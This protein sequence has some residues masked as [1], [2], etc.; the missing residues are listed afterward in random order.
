[1][2]EKR[3]RGR[4]P[5]ILAILPQPGRPGREVYPGEFLENGDLDSERIVQLKTA[6]SLEEFVTKHDAAGQLIDPDPPS[7]YEA[8]TDQERAE[9]DADWN[10]NCETEKNLLAMHKQPEVL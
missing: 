1:M 9:A 8:P 4:G 3:L 2:A 7:R 6:G 5:G 10:V